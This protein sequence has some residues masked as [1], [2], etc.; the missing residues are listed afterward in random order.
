MSCNAPAEVCAWDPNADWWDYE[1]NPGW[2]D[3]A[4]QLQVPNTTGVGYTIYYYVADARDGHSGDENVGAGWVDDGGYLVYGTIPAGYGIWT[5]GYVNAEETVED[6]S[7][8]FAGA[9]CGDDTVPVSGDSAFRLRSIPYP[10]TN[11]LNEDIADWATAGFPA[12]CAWDPNA[13]WWDYE[14]NPGF[15]DNAAQI[16]VPNTTGVGYT[17]YY[18]VQD[19]RDGHNDDENAGAAWVDDG[20]YLTYDKMPVGYGIWLKTC[21]AEPVTI[22]FKK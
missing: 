10:K 17:I 7:F 8:T 20:G 3:H 5:R 2:K 1:E 4:P 9:V 11:G 16:Q 22:N 12:V 14:E 19:A 18:Y 15:R 13:D 21:T 6:T